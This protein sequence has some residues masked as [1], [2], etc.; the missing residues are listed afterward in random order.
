MNKKSEYLI[1]S[2]KKN[3]ED[4][5]S[6]SYDEIEED[7]QD[8]VMYSIIKCNDEE[9]GTQN[10]DKESQKSDN[11]EKEIEEEEKYTINMM[12]FINIKKDTQKRDNTLNNVRINPAIKIH[13]DN[14]TMNTMKAMKMM[15]SEVKIHEEK[16]QDTHLKELNVN[17]K[18]RT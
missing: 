1:S 6:T 5:E 2:K 4:E 3:H 16:Q 15:A 11:Q 12:K 7:I 13:D 14:P 8:V 17:K 10:D 18:R 9:E